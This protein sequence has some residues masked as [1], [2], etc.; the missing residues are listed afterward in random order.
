MYVKNLGIAGAYF[1]AA[2]AGSYVA[3]SPIGAS[4]IWPAAGVALAGLHLYGKKL[5]PGLFFGVLCAQIY[6]FQDF[7]SLEKIIDSMVMGSIIA[8]GSTLQ[9]LFGLRLL[10]KNNIASDDPLLG[11]VTI[12]KFI[13]FGAFVST[14]VAS[15]IGVTTLLLNSIITLDQL[16]L[17]WLTWWIG[18]SIG[19][20]IFTPIILIFLARPKQLWRQ[21]VKS[22]VFPLLIILVLISILFSHSVEQ[23]RLQ[24]KANFDLAVERFHSAL[25][26][27]ISAFARDSLVLKGIFDGSKSV[28]REDFDTFTAPLT[29]GRTGLFALE[30]IPRVT[31]NDRTA[32]E[33]KIDANFSILEPD[34]QRVLVSAKKRPEYFPI[35]FIQPWEQNQKAYGYDIATNPIA[36]QTIDKAKITG[37]AVFSEPVKLIQ[38]KAENYGYVSYAPVFNKQ[39]PADLRG[40]VASIFSVKDIVQNSI[41]AEH[42]LFNF[43]IRDGKKVIYNNFPENA[44]H[45]LSRFQI[46]LNLPINIANRK[47]IVE[48]L[49]SLFF[50]NQHASWTIWLI[51]L[52]GFLFAGSSGIALLILSGRNMLT[53][54]L[55]KQR[56]KEIKQA[57]VELQE[58]NTDLIKA[59]EEVKRAGKAKDLFFASMSHELRTPLNA[60]LGFSQIT[61]NDH[62]LTEEQRDNLKEINGAGEHLLQLINN[63]LDFAKV[64]AGKI[65]MANEEVNFSEI[66]SSCH[67]ILK[68]QMQKRG[69]IFEYDPQQIKTVMLRGDSLRVKQI[70]LNLLSNAVK[71]NVENGRVSLTCRFLSDGQWRIEV[72]DTGIGIPE[73][74]I[75]HLFTPFERLDQEDSQIEGTGIGLT[76]SKTFVELMHGRIGVDSQDG[77]GSTF[78]FEISGQVIDIKTMITPPDE[79]ID[80]V[81]ISSKHFF[82]ILYV[83]DDEINRLIVERIFKKF[84]NIKVFLAEDG[85]NGM[86]IL[87]DIKPDMILLDINMPGM[88]GYELCPLIKEKYSNRPVIAMSADATDRAIKMSKSVGFDDYLT[89]PIDIPALQNM[90]KFYLEKRHAEFITDYSI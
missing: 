74:K 86:S 39:N 15:S 35:V 28:S 55:V 59:N 90:V 36:K 7:S 77:D 2:I 73:N 34:D 57:K 12:L 19:I 52:G 33:Q 4:P 1:L 8:C 88:S 42:N 61:Q 31:D 30:W 83:D 65:S 78:W 69:I 53:E 67:S 20:L 66:V 80:E 21:R 46:K 44:V 14:I 68:H 72:T 89:K 63:I 24:H 49:P 71:Y 26:S 79:T 3:V 64:E 22:V 29:K 11:E 5:L 85:Q 17:S 87:D 70:L 58:Q 54:A 76:I 84:K 45:G 60:V 37:T 82:S 13:F 81:Q 41:K 18:D 27:N 75:A 10:R 40:V 56:T 6:S 48:Y 23:E 32:F 9:A 47:L 50:A 38:D 25:S 43:L 62:N 16:V 51:L